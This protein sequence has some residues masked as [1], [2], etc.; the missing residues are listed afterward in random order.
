MSD[1]PIIRKPA[2]IQEEIDDLRRYLNGIPE[3]L[4]TSGAFHSYEQRMVEL[5][6]ELVVSRN[7]KCCETNQN[8]KHANMTSNF[9]QAKCRLTHK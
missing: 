5:N 7:Q 1:E 6:R 3:Q 9:C 4:R 8:L 2:I